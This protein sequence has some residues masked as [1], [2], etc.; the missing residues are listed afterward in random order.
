MGTNI[1][2]L[3]VGGR[4]PP[5]PPFHGG[6]REAAAVEPDQGP[7]C[8]EDAAVR[9]TDEEWALLDPDQRAL[10]MDVR[11][12]N[13]GIVASLDGIPKIFN[14]VTFPPHMHIVKNWKSRTRVTMR[15]SPE[16]RSQIKI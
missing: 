6:R 10:H 4:R 15:K 7:V 14:L 12:E 1:Q 16:R 3:S 9:F 5:D 8:L 2:I 13:R 11:E